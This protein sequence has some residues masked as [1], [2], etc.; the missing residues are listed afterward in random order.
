MIIRRGGLQTG[1]ALIR[2]NCWSGAGPFDE[3]LGKIG[4]EDSDLFCWLRRQ[5]CVFAWAAN[6]E[7]LERLEEKR[8]YIRWHLRRLPLRMG[9]FRQRPL[10]DMGL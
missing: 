7:V 5:G 6:A 8:R 9:L 2:R 10:S 3:G 1:N 4:G